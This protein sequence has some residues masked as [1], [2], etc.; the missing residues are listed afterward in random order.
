[1]VLSSHLEVADV[2]IKDYVGDF[3][4]NESSGA[5]FISVHYN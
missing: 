2:K 4:I 5:N 1:M 3:I